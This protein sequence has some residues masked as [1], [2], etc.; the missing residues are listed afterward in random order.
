MADTARDRLPPL[1][2]LQAF[3]AAARLG[4]FTRAAAELKLTPGAVSR[5]VRALEDWCAQTLFERHGPQVR[6]TRDGQELLS[7]LG[8]PLN[9]LHA[10]IYP[11][12]E[13][14]RQTLVVAT[15]ASL[16]RA[17]LVPRLP[18]FTARHPHIALQVHTDYALTRPPPRVAMVAL[19]YGARPSEGLHSEVLFEDRLVAVASPAVAQALGTEAAAWPASRWLQ[20]LPLDLRPWLA[21]AGLPETFA[22]LGMAFNDAD[23]VL[24]AAQQGLGVTVTRLSLA[25]PRLQA[26][27][28]AMACGVVCRSPRDNLLVVREDSA[29]LPAVRAFS[30]WVREEAVAWT[31]TV[32][33][34]EA[35]L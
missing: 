13:E 17:W 6:L 34:I 32:A 22:P 4:S 18:R 14:S 35:G 19:R 3:E 15:L 20:H 2:S 29:T 9:A 30:A 10:A 31:Q 21:A 1:F 26:G 27:T 11:A 7:R 8:G 24:D 16:A 23:V 25:W 33:A 5:Q 28:L 12:P